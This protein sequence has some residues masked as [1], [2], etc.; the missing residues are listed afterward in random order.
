MKLLHVFM[1]LGL[2]LG[3]TSGLYSA[4]EGTR[5]LPSLSSLSRDY[6]TRRIKTIVKDGLHK[7]APVQSVLDEI[8]PWLKN[9]TQDAIDMIRIE[10]LKNYAVKTFKVLRIGGSVTK[11]QLFDGRIIDRVYEMSPRESHDDPYQLKSNWGKLNIDE[12]IEKYSTVHKAWKLKAPHPFIPVL[13][14]PVIPANDDDDDD[15]EPFFLLTPT[16][17]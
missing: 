2:A 14:S 15:E 5:P 10:L 11:E 8:Q 4:S 16:A 17:Q 7:K 6:I 9:L 3:L 1:T 12:I 13:R